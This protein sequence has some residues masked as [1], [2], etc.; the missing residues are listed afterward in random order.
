[1]PQKTTETIGSDILVIGSM[2]AVPEIMTSKI[3]MFIWPSGHLSLRQERYNSRP[4]FTLDLFCLLP[5]RPQAMQ[6]LFE[7][8][9]FEGQ[10]CG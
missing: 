2:R 5:T 7:N 1:M 8:M 4:S 10:D 6:P 3:L 9:R